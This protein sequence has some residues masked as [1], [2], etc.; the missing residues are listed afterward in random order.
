M[1]T[2]E[3]KGARPGVFIT[4]EGG[5]GAG[6]TTHLNFLSESLRKLGYDV[7]CL[8]EP[9]GTSIGEALRKVVLDG[10]NT[11]MS[12]ETELL[13]YEAARAQLVC[14]VIIPALEQGKVVIC[15]RFFDSTVAYQ[16]YGRGLPLDFVETANEFACK[17]V[18]PHRTILLTTGDED[19]AVIA[20]LQR[21]TKHGNA[22]RLEQAGLEF[23]T[24]VTRGFRAVAAANA[25]RIRVVPS[26]G[27]KPDTARA[28]FR[29]LADVF[30]WGDVD[31]R[32]PQEFFDAILV[33]NTDRK[34]VV[35]QGGLGAAGE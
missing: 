1:A 24:D 21:A 15:D 33:K 31:E 32:F 26:N 23:H 30:G 13:I 6:K 17:G 9:G 22:D 25:D 20:G 29:E 18:H 16:A 12:S 14:E 10:R 34:A 27:P 3:G 35:N 11:E 2:G 7:V 28:I 8:R 19:D 5:E 4:F